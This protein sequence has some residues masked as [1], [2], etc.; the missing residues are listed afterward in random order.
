[1]KF[2][3][4]TVGFSLVHCFFHLYLKNKQTKKTSSDLTVNSIR[5]LGHESYVNKYMKVHG[6]RDDKFSIYM[7]IHRE[8]T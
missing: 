3:S 2:Y 8:C 7:Q 4:G 5:N 1:M 6:S